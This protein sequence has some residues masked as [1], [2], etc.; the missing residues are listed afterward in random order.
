MRDPAGSHGV[1]LELVSL[2]LFGL[3]AVKLGA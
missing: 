1:V 3:I 2:S